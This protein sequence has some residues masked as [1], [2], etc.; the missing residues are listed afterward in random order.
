ME[1]GIKIGIPFGMSPEEADEILLKALKIKEDMPASSSF[2][3]PA[4]EKL[5]KDA[6]K[7]YNKLCQE[8][9]DEIIE[10]LEK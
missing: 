2:E 5:A 4:I 9:L 10:V 7:T 6:A 1:K 8:M 3:D